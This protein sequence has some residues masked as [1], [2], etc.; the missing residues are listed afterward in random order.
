MIK[1]IV[2]T[3]IILCLAITSSYAVDR[4][5]TTQETLKD[6]S[7]IDLYWVGVYEGRDTVYQ[8]KIGDKLIHLGDQDAAGQPIFNLKHNLIALPYCADDGCKSK[9]NILNLSKKKILSP[10]ELNYKGQIYIECRWV[11]KTLEIQVDHELN[12]T[13]K[14]S[15]HK[16]NITSNGIVPQ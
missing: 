7:K 8:I 5:W 15:I 11:E 14:I 13:N 3:S 16:Y 12:K 9:V 4:T 6:G 1:K 2:Q 10:I